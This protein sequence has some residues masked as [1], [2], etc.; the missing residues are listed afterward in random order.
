M[1]IKMKKDKTMLKW[2]E[3]PRD[4]GMSEYIFFSIG[5][6]YDLGKL[7]KVYCYWLKNYTEILIPHT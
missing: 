6:I 4:A 1:A 7:Q 3:T 2:V 5:K